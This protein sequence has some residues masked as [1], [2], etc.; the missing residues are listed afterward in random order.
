M[1]FNKTKSSSYGDERWTPYCCSNLVHPP[2]L[3][4]QETLA[5]A[6]RSHD[7]KALVVCASSPETPNENQ[8]Q[9]LM[10][11]LLYRLFCFRIGLVT[12][13]RVQI[14]RDRYLTQQSSD[15][16]ALLAQVID[17]LSEDCIRV[18]CIIDISSPLAPADMSHF[19]DLFRSLF[20]IAKKAM[21]GIIINTCYPD[22]FSCL[23]SDHPIIPL[24]VPPLLSQTPSSLP[25]SQK[26]HLQ[27]HYR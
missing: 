6:V 14:T 17:T 18:V 25:L 3:A 27:Q 24:T 16:I 10:C 19:R 1:A 5:E 12:P 22:A 20:P 23:S 2:N 11:T 15:L 26:P 21:G 7:S 4:L 13:H 9:R 8:F